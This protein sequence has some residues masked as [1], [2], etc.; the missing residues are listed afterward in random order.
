[1]MKRN[2]LGFAY[3]ASFFALFATTNNAQGQLG[4]GFGGEAPKTQ[5][6]LLV[7]EIANNPAVWSRP[8]GEEPAWLSNGKSSVDAT[9]TLRAKLNET[10]DIELSG[11]F[12]TTK[13]FLK[14]KLGLEVD[15]NLQALE[16][17]GIDVATLP[18]LPAGTGPLREQLR[19]MLDPLELTYRVFEG[20]I[21][22]TSKT[23]AID[24]PSMRFYDLSHVARDNSSLAD[25]L[26]AI[27][28]SVAPDSWEQQGGNCT[29]VPIGQMLLVRTS[30]IDQLEIERLLAR[31]SANQPAA[32]ATERTVDPLVP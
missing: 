11:D 3:V 5:V 10:V 30:E 1:M 7:E 2:V 26:N 21:E 27:Y 32:L 20:Y 28:T 25:I 6:E 18:G 24:N 29:C 13:D 15:V 31:L 4:G 17:E 19:R 16:D 14:E 12:G 8:T 9:E 23:E 22:I